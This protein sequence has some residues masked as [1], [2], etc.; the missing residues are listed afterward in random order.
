M[1]LR[2]SVINSDRK[3]MIN[4]TKKKGGGKKYIYTHIYIYIYIYTSNI[5]YVINIINTHK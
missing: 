3:E 1:L 4:T 5:Q 2:S